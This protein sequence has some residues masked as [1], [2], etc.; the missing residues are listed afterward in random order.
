[1]KG[2]LQQK[3]EVEERATGPGKNGTWV[4]WSAILTVD[5]KEISYTAFNDKE[6]LEKDVSALKLGSEIEF[7]TE[8]VKGYLNVKQKTKIK[9]IKE[10]DNK[11]IKVPLAKPKFD[12]K[13]LEKIWKDSADFVVKYWE[14][15]GQDTW[16][17]DMIG[18]AINTLFMQKMKSRGVK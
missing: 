13:E 2:V 10:G 11:P 17:V 6:G 7:E 1:V 12:D 18:P 9:V 16:S 3:S 4:L 14:D 8:I 5:G 15:K